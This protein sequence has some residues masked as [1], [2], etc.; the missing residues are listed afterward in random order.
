MK[1][2]IGADEVGYGCW[3]G[4][5]YVV[6][7]KAPEDWTLAGLN[8][9]KK[10]S[11][12]RRLEM[13]KKLRQLVNDDEIKFAVAISSSGEIDHYGVA[14]CLKLC[15]GTVIA[16]LYCEESE[17]I[18]DGTLKGSEVKRV[19]EKYGSTFNVDLENI[20]TEV[21]ADGKFPTVMGAS[22]LAKTARDAEMKIIQH[23]VYPKYNFFSHV[24]YGTKEHRAA[25]DNFGLT[26]IHRLSYEPMKSMK[27]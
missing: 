23:S 18:L 24:G 12:K 6:G 14:D 15:Y 13:E 26:P 3:A 16:Q 4:S 20:R 7:L 9:S 5:L 27:K 22:I 11:E 1:Y 17:V 21:K 2:T 19:M 8:D 10:L 25:I